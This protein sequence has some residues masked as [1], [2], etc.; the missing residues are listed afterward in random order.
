MINR[1]LKEGMAQKRK[2]GAKRSAP[3]LRQS[4]LGSGH[5]STS[6]TPHPDHSSVLGSLQK[7]QGQLAGIER[8]ILARRYCAD[9]LIQFRAAGSAM[10]VIEADIF[11]KHVKNCVVQAVRSENSSE[12]DDKIEE[13]VKLILKN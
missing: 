4:P 2:L 13:L 12:L 8:M 11:R 9:I 1:S 3:S 5:C 7:V 10:R 6:S